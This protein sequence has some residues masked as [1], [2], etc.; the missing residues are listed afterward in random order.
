MRSPRPS[1]GIA[2]PAHAPRDSFSLLILEST[3]RAVDS[4]PPSRTTKKAMGSP[5]QTAGSTS[6]HRSTDSCMVPERQSDRSTHSQPSGSAPR[7]FLARPTRLWTTR[8]RRNPSNSH[9]QTRATYPQTPRHP[10]ASAPPPPRGPGCA[11][12]HRDRASTGC[13]RC[14]AATRLAKS[15]PVR[16][17]QVASDNR[18]F[19]AFRSAP[20]REHWGSHLRPRMTGR[21]T[22]S[23]SW[24]EIGNCRR[25]RESCHLQLA[26]PLPRLPQVIS[27][28]HPQPRPRT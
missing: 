28:L 21:Q 26:H 6:P 19:T 2:N 20:I 27:R 9:P 16:P 10:A 17:H 7:P 13:Q 18:S 23:E 4:Q 11:P 3:A 24:L 1:H 8:S 12:A 5:S 22:L 14:S 15:Q 25:R